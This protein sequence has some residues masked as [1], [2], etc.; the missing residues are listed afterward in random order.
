MQERTDPNT[1]TRPPGR[2][3]SASLRLLASPRLPSLL[4][5]SSSPSRP[6]RSRCIERPGVSA[7][8]F[9]QVVRLRRGGRAQWTGSMRCEGSGARPRTGGATADTGRRGRDGAADGRL[10][11]LRS[12][13]RTPCSLVGPALNAR[14]ATS[15]E[16]F[17][18]ARNGG[19]LDHPCL[20]RRVAA[21]GV[22][23]C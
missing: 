9:A 7:W 19:R 14:N 5:L 6:A 22:F 2:L 16:K 3:P 23:S 10:P 21:P 20:W 17:K 8:A 13:G 12:A 1:A 11:N 15:H 18:R 4:L